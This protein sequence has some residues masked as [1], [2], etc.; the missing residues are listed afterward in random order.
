MITD[1]STS[2]L[3]YLFIELHSQF[4][5]KDLG[6]LHYFFGVEVPRTIIDLFFFSQTK[7]TVDL[8][9][10]VSMNG[11]KSC[12][13]PALTPTK[14]CALMGDPLSNLTFYWSIVGT[15]QYPTLI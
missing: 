8:L 1:S 2:Y 10:R 14:L 4:V 3:F 11:S 7:Y 15:L 13:S 6:S 9:K 5:M 12:S